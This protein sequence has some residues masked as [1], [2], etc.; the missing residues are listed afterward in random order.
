M[1]MFAPVVRPCFLGRYFNACN[2][3]DNHN[4]M[5]QSG[6]ALYKYWVT[7][8]GYFRLATTLELVVVIIDGMLL[9]CYGVS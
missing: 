3:I 1:F 2:E 8:S 4:R 5:Q 7:Q 9:Y 6:M